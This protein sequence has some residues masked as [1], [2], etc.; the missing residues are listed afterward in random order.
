MYTTILIYSAFSPVVYSGNT[1]T[2]TY[3]HELVYMYTAVQSQ[4]AVSA[5]S[6][7]KQILPFDLAEK[8]IRKF[9]WWAAR[10]APRVGEYRR[11]YI[12]R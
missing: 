4:K 9:P 8:S 5:D 11:N 10:V 3:Y 2:G 7:S 6:T 12:G 1:T